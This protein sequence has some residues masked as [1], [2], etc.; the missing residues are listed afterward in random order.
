MNKQYQ[1]WNL[2][3]CPIHWFNTVKMK[4]CSCNRNPNCKQCHGF[5][6]KRENKNESIY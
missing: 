2:Y 6:Y 4:T 3:N 1:P 5:G